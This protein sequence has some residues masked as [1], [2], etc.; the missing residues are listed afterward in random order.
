M[1]YVPPYIVLIQWYGLLDLSLD[2]QPLSGPYDLCVELAIG[3]AP[4]V[5]FLKLDLGILVLASHSV[6][7]KRRH[8]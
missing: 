2:L 3:L 1:N 6:L 7:I 4:P 5:L 8:I